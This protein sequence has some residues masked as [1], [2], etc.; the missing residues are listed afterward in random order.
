MHHSLAR[1]HRHC[2]QYCRAVSPNSWVPL[3]ICGADFA[4][5]DITVRI[6]PSVSTTAVRHPGPGSEGWTRSARPCSS[7]HQTPQTTAMVPT[8][9]WTQATL[10]L[11]RRLFCILCV[12]PLWFRDLL[13]DDVRHTSRRSHLSVTKRGYFGS[14]S[15]MTLINLMIHSISSQDRLS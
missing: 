9:A 8:S 5:F 13:A 6:R 14:C 2:T 12:G 1:H 11:E 15:I 10:S 3:Q 4:F 7:S